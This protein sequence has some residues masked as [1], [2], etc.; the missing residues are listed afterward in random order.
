M[1]I[2]A[3]LV[4][5]FLARWIFGIGW[6]RVSHDAEMFVWLRWVKKFGSDQS[7]SRTLIWSKNALSGHVDFLT[8]KKRK[9]DTFGRLVRIWFEFGSPKYLVFYAFR[10]K[11]ELRQA[12]TG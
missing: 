7:W 2:S 12:P 1:N 4:F 10:Q 11:N 9:I 8:K 6:I 5:K 3:N